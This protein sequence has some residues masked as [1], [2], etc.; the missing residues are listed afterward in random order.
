MEGFVIFNSFVMVPYKGQLVRK[1]ACRWGC[2]ILIS[3]Y[4]N[5]LELRTL[6][7]VVICLDLFTNVPPAAHVF[8]I[9]C[10][11]QFGQVII[12]TCKLLPELFGVNQKP[13]NTDT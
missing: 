6:I 2:L 8:V 5:V 11:K 3:S 7:L 13:V 10:S 4:L 12:R 1:F 9:E